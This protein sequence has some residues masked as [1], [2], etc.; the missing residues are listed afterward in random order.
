M[1]QVETERQ[2]QYD[3]HECHREPLQYVEVATHLHECV[4]CIII[5]VE[6]EQVR[7]AAYGVA[8]AVIVALA[9]A[10]SIVGTAYRS[11]HKE[12]PAVRLLGQC[13]EVALRNDIG[14]IERI[15]F[16]FGISSFE[17]WFEGFGTQVCLC[18]SLVDKTAHEGLSFRCPITVPSLDAFLLNTKR[19]E[20]F[21][22]MRITLYKSYALERV[23]FMV[24]QSKIVER[25]LH[26]VS[27]TCKILCLVA[28][29]SLFLEQLF[30]MTGNLRFITQV[31][32]VGI[33]MCTANYES[34]KTDDDNHRKCDEQWTFAVERIGIDAVCPLQSGWFCFLCQH[35][36]QVDERE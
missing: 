23:E 29:E 10:H 15:G 28:G 17:E 25:L 7:V 1:A 22:C 5:R 31:V 3:E 2:Q 35:M 20:Q 33:E 36:R 14:T 21:V 9:A 32:H 19:N 34:S 8:N 6:H 12:I 27:A 24:E 13:G 26:C 4:G 16:V 11:E 18:C 30:R